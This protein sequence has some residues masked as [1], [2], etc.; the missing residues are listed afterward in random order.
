MEVDQGSCYLAEVEHSAAMDRQTGCDVGKE[1][2]REAHSLVTRT[3]THQ[4]DFCQGPWLPTLC[5]T[6]WSSA[7]GMGDLEL[8]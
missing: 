2:S 7:E 5:L 8:A 4:R 3:L 1:S 6:S